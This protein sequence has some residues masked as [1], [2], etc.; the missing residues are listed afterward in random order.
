MVAETQ[1]RMST[2]YRSSRRSATSTRISRKSKTVHPSRSTRSAENRRE[3]RQHVG[4]D[5]LG[6]TFEPRAAQR[7]KVEGAGLIAADDAGGAR[8]C[9]VAR[10]GEAAGAIPALSTGPR[11]KG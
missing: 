7:G 8:A 1:Q 5:R 11:S 9:A 10:D 3:P 6:E 2:S 4:D